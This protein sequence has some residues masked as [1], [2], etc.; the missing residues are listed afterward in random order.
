MQAKPLYSD[1]SGIRTAKQWMI[2]RMLGAL[3]GVFRGLRAFSARSRASP[4]TAWAVESM[5]FAQVM[6][7]V[8]R[9][10]FKDNLA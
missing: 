10:F 2:E 4:W 3:V 7:A 5:P 8:R 1:T 9:K 6:R